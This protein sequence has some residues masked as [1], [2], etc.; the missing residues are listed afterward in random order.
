MTSIDPM[1]QIEVEGE[2]RRL[3]LRLTQVTE[4]VASA[5]VEA[6]EADAAYDL[7]EAHALLAQTGKGGTVPEKKARALIAVEEDYI[8]AKRT[9]AVARS[10]FEA[11]RNLRAQ[12]EAL[13]SLNA[14]MRDQ[15]THPIGRG[16]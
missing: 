5:A 3:S 9:E 12:L 8:R 1:A 10:L 15:V 14:N 7:A 13:R 6:A 4:E 11:G 2:I 16:G